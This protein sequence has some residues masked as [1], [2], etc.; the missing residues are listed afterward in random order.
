MACPCGIKSMQL[1][2]LAGHIVEEKAGHVQVGAG[3]KTLRIFGY[4]LINYQKQRAN[5]TIVLLCS[6]YGSISLPPKG[7]GR[8]RSSPEK[9]ISDV[10]L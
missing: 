5:M 2:E 3:G 8:N 9:A 4:Q 1:K 6:A 10:F 7:H